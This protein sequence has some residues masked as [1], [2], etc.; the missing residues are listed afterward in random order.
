[1]LSQVFVCPQGGDLCMISLPVWLPDPMCL[2]GRVG[3]LCP[4][5]SVGRTPESEKRAVHILLECFLVMIFVTAQ[6]KH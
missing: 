4:G 3:G 5:F 6:F 2:P 1:M